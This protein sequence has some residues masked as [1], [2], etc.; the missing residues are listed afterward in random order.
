MKKRTEDETYATLVPVADW[1]R[2]RWHHRRIGHPDI[3]ELRVRFDEM[4]ARNSW[5][6]A[7]NFDELIERYKHLY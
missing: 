2:I 1:F 4:I 5:D 7:G 6:L 3:W